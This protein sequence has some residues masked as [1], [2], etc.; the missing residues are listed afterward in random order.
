MSQ[1]RNVNELFLFGYG[2]F[3]DVWAPVTEATI[4]IVVSIIGG[5]FWGLPGLLL[6]AVISL[7]LIIGLWK[8]YFLYQKGFKESLW[9]YW[10]TITKFLSIFL[11]SWLVSHLIL[12]T[13]FPFDPGKN[14]FR[15]VQYAFFVVCVFSIVEYALMVIFD[16]GMRD[17]SLRMKERLLKARK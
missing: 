10:L 9:S 5:Y 12:T 4:S 8:P 6:G 3:Y 1:T 15:W 2:L 13:F 11:V 17:F 14:Y 16:K 7:L